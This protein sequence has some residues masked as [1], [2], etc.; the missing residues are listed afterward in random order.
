MKPTNFDRMA[1]FTHTHSHTPIQKHIHCVR[2][3]LFFLR[4]WGFI[5]GRAFV[6]LYFVS[7]ILAVVAF[8]SLLFFFFGW[9]VGGDV[10]TWKLLFSFS[11]HC[12]F[13]AR[14]Q[15]NTSHRHASTNL[16]VHT[17]TLRREFTHTY[18]YLPCLTFTEDFCLLAEVALM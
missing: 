2:Y 13:R 3:E 14:T 11:L 16:H 5:V 1:L 7:N 17:Y 9:Y 8:I 15:T 12:E 6:A 4:L 18:I 10:M